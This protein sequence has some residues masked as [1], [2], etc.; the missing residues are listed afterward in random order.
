MPYQIVV[1][2]YVGPFEGLYLELSREKPS[3]QSFALATVVEGFLSY[4]HE[5]ASLDL[6]EAS[7]FL[8]MA[9]TLLDIKARLLF[10]QPK[11]ELESDEDT[12]VDGDS[13][14]HLAEYRRY[15]QVAEWLAS[16]GHDRER[17]ISR[18]PIELADLGIPGPDPLAQVTMRDLL[19]AFDRILLLSEDGPEV[20]VPVYRDQWTVED[21]VRWLEEQ[22]SGSGAI[23]F[24]AVFLPGTGRMM[25]IVTF[26]ALLEL[27]KLGVVG[28]RQGSP[29]E[30][31]MLIWLGRPD[32][33]R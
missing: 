26:L 12:L 7:S 28:A 14:A 29:D 24:G 11:P 5:A 17:F 21:Q 10:P 31:I 25:L 30:E 15:Q 8:V 32:V 4:L 27:I 19:K 6:D 23:A 18:E 20:L 22:V 9:A 13:E 16:V 2:N 33:E 3:I 1:Q